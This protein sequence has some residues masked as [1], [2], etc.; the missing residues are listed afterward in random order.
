M[1]KEMYLTVGE[2]IAIHLSCISPELGVSDNPMIALEQQTQ[3][4][5]ALACG[6][7]RAHAAVELKKLVSGGYAVRRSC[8]V[9]GRG[10]KV[11][12]YYLTH[13]GFVMVGGICKLHADKTVQELVK[14]PG[15][16]FVPKGITREEISS[17]KAEISSMTSRL[18]RLERKVE[19]ME[20]N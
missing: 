2:R 10:G 15:R 5:A 3:D 19:L 13:K 12:S 17:V 16:S 9:L 1:T 7:S 4:G 11:A 8:H 18:N 6:I 20:A 14:M